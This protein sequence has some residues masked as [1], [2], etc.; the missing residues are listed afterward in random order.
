VKKGAAAHL[1]GADFQ[2]TLG[3]EG[4]F[5]LSEERVHLTCTDHRLTLGWEDFLYFE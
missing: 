1:T 2:L 4:F 5:G 3:R